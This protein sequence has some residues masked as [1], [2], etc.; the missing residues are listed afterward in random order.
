MKNYTD[1]DT[2]LKELKDLVD[3]FVNDRNWQQ[4]HTPRKLAMNIAIEAAELMEQFQWDKE[5]D[6]D[7]EE[8][9]DELADIIFNCLNFANINNIDVSAAFLSKYKKLE[10]KYPVEIFNADNNSL[11]NYHKIKQAHRTKRSK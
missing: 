8:V 2:T 7:L 10:K 4:H 5:K 1:Q 11:D 3:K 9:A 6:P